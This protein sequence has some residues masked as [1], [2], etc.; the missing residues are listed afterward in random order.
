MKNMKK[1]AKVSTS[2]IIEKSKILKKIIKRLKL[3]EYYKIQYYPTSFS[4]LSIVKEHE[5]IINLFF[6]SKHL[7][8]YFSLF[9]KFYYF[10]L[11]NKIKKLFK[12]FYLN[13]LLNYDELK[14]FLD[15][16]SIKMSLKLGI[17]KKK[18]RSIQI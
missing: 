8:F 12:F 1:K 3:D 7:L 14:S 5:N 9:P 11:D 4:F 6:R 2:K 18:K 15:N 10:L 17:L 16:N 13:D